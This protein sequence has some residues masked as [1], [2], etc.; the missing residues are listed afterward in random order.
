MSSFGA[1][2]DKLKSLLDK[3]NAEIE[4]LERQAGQ[5]EV[6]HRERY[7][8]QI[9]GLRQ[10]RDELKCKIDEAGEVTE[11]GSE[12]IMTGLDVAWETLKE[13]IRK[14]KEYFQ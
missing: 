2:F 12:T 4:R 11:S 5:V 9:N 3:W 14:A 1:Y 8:Q 6:E 13:S 7:R 10:Q